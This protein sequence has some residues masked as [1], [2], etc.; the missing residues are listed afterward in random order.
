MIDPKKNNNNEIKDALLESDEMEYSEDLTFDSNNQTNNNSDLKQKMRKLLLIVIL[1]VV[2]LIIILLISSLVAP[3]NRDYNDVE[4]IMQKAAIK[5]YKDNENMIPRSGSTA[6]VS[7][8]KLADLGYMNELSKYRSSDSCTGKVVVYNNDDEIIYTPYL[9]CGENYATVE[10]FKKVTMSKNIVTSGNG[11]YKSGNEYVFRGDEVNN[12]VQ[13]NGNLWRIVKITSNNDVVLIYQDDIGISQVWDNRYNSDK[14]YK[15]GIN[16][17]DVS[18]INT[19]L[20]EIFKSNEES[21]DYESDVGIFNKNTRKLAVTYKLC[22]GA[23]SKNTTQKDNSL[24]CSTTIDGKIGLLTLSDYANASLDANCDIVTK[25]SCQ[26][27]NYL[28]NKDLSGWWLMTPSTD[29]SSS[30]YYI[31]QSGYVDTTDASNSKSLRPVVHLSSKAMYKSGN[32][33]EE[34]PYILK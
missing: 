22:V 30:V 20:N 18:R 28:V 26:N 11:L 3:K 8:Q 4:K 16:R 25:K 32:G 14:N 33:T 17:Y 21:N 5:Y 34:K 31:N 10:L 2:I 6:E 19:R 9:D 7:A 23:R 29:N 27:Y 24:E 12:Y 15:A 13:I 1:C